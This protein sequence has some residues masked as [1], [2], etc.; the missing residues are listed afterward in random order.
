[1]K[2]HDWTN[3]YHDKRSANPRLESYIQWELKSP[4]AVS[5]G[6]WCVTPWTGF[7]LT[8]LVMA[9]DCDTQ[10]KISSSSSLWASRSGSKAEDNLQWQYFEYC[11]R[12]NQQDIPSKEITMNH[13]YEMK[14]AICTIECPR[15]YQG[16]KKWHIKYR[17]L[18]WKPWFIMLLLVKW[19]NWLHD[20]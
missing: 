8:T 6:I 4:N 3:R 5:E 19:P 16:L 10:I 2:I 13:H 7:E 15:V 14:I 11:L 1:M 18:V 17:L 9:P 12:Q 20:V